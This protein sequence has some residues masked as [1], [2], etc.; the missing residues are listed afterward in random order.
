MSSSGKKSLRLKKF[1]DFLAGIVIISLLGGVA[2]NLMSLENSLKIPTKI[3]SPGEDL[4][5][6]LSEAKGD[7]ELTLSEDMTLS[8][9]KNKTVLGHKSMGTVTIDG[10][11]QGS[12]TAVGE[13]E[14]VISPVKGAKLVFKNLTINDATKLAGTEYK[15]YL[16][17][18]GD[19]VFENCTFTNSIRLKESVDA[20]FKD[21]TFQSVTTRY[22]S[23]WMSDG[24]VNFENCRFEGYRALKVHE[25]D[26][27]EDVESVRVK[28]CVFYNVLEKP[29]MAIGEVDKETSISV[30]ESTFD[31]CLGW[32]YEGSL[33]GKDGLYECDTRLNE[34]TFKESNNKVFNVYYGMKYKIVTPNKVSSVPNKMFKTDGKYPTRFKSGELLTVSDLNDIWYDDYTDYEFCGWY[35]DETLTKAFD[36]IIYDNMNYNLYAKVLVGYWTANY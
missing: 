24:N 20:S 23:V 1:W 8:V 12:I 15:D 22:Y 19:L 29:G 13:K 35:L 26:K 27:S 10:N 18:G 33:V 6:T 16:Y 11:N 14:S 3:L 36:G 30:T 21:C 17:F 25:F 5:V 32:D 9:L 34:F 2:I 31:G 4:N 28:S 7:C